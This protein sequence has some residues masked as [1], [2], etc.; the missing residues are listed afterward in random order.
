MENIVI[1]AVLFAAFLHAFWNFLLKV[2]DDTVLNMYAVVLG[3]LPLALIF[4]MIVGLP[5][6][7]ALPYVLISAALH[8]GYQIFLMNAY[9]FGALSNIYPIARGL[10]PLLLTVMTLGSV[11]DELSRAEM[12][13]IFLVAGSLISFGLAQYRFDKNGPLGMML[14]IITG[15]FIALYTLADA[16]GVRISASA[17]TFYCLVELINSAMFTGYYLCFHRD[18]LKRLPRDGMKVLLVGGSTSFTAYVIVLWACLTLPV[19]LV[20]SLR[21]TSVLIVMMLG[22]MFLKEKLTLPKLL[23]CI[24]VVCGVA[25]MRLG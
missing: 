22:V 14:A 13:G 7:E 19:G 4:M 5:P 1:L 2:N 10:S 23:T 18:V 16:L 6:L 9:R 20:S 21:E 24:T 8:T 11:Q 17:L 3:H 12:I 25:L 15:G